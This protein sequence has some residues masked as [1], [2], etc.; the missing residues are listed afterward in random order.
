MKVDNIYVNSRN[1]ILNVISEN[2]KK[3]G[4]YIELFIWSNGQEKTTKLLL[5]EGE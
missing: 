2:L 1:D 3:T 4:E 5:S